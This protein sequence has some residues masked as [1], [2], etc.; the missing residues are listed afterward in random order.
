MHLPVHSKIGAGGSWIE[1]HS[2]YL[3]SDLL[4][5]LHR[6]MPIFIAFSR[7]S[8][9]WQSPRHLNNSLNLKSI[10]NAESDTAISSPSLISSLI[11]L[12]KFGLVCSS[13]AFGA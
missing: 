8:C 11:F 13:K 10:A 1:S 2:R 3:K 7:Y 9:S 5:V 4:T 12:L 6:I